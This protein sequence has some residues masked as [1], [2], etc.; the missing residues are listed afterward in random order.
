MHNARN[1][2]SFNANGKRTMTHAERMARRKSKHAQWHIVFRSRI[3]GCKDC[4]AGGFTP[5]K[6]NASTRRS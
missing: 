3:C 1:N 5:G 2:T 6:R 4:L